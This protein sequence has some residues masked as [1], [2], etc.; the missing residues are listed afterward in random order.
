MSHNTK[1]QEYYQALEANRTPEAVELETVCHYLTLWF[2]VHPD[3][4]DEIDEFNKSQNAMRTLAGG[5]DATET[6]LLLTDAKQWYQSLY[7]HS[8]DLRK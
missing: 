2:I 7:A 6:Y 5:D 1:T 8:W 4:S 3:C